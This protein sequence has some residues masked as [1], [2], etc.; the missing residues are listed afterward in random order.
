MEPVR[1]ILAIVLVLGLLG[2]TL[3]WLRRVGGARLTVK[4]P[5]R[6]STRQMRSI[7]Q[8]RLTPQHS[9]HMVKVGD[10]ILLVALSPGG[11]SVLRTTGVEVTAVDRVVSRGC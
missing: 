1:Q 8:L 2:G 10:Q 5:G 9:L 4:R 7:E 11:C 3:Y 6:A